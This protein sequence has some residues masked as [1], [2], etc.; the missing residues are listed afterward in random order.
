MW[1]LRCCG[2]VKK[3][4]PSRQL[5][6]TGEGKCGMYGLGVWFIGSPLAGEACVY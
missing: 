3:E 1:S 5:V 2:I 6:G 4:M